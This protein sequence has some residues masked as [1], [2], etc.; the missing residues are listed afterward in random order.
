MPTKFPDIIFGQCNFAISNFLTNECGSISFGRKLYSVNQRCIIVVAKQH[1]PLGHAGSTR[2]MMRASSSRNHEKRSHQER[3]AKKLLLRVSL[4]NF[5]AYDFF[6]TITLPFK[7][8]VEKSIMKYST[9]V[10]KQ[11]R[12]TYKLSTAAITFA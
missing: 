12:H 4:K 3:A 6:H 11:G 1:Y 7:Y 8:A 5:A 9:S 10:Y 2:R